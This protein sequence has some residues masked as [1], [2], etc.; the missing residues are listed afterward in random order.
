MSGY[1][2]GALDLQDNENENVIYVDPSF[3]SF[4]SLL[5]PSGSSLMALVT[6]TAPSGAMS[7]AP[8][9]VSIGP[10]CCLSVQEVE[11]GCC[12]GQQWTAVDA[13]GFFCWP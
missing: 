9:P 8:V 10:T 6:A 7:E 5:S 4:L 12:S 2:E 1:L 3:L 11:L 13:V